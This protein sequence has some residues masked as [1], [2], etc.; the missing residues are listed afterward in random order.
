MGSGRWAAAEVVQR[1]NRSIGQA[2]GAG[3]ERDKGGQPRKDEN[4]PTGRTV[5]RQTVGDYRADAEPP[6]GSGSIPRSREE[7]QLHQQAEDD[8]AVPELE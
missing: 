5:P 7:H 8:R 1:C 6:S 2:H 3:R 4:C